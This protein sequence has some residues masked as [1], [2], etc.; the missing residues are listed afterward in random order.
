MKNNTFKR[1]MAFMAITT[2]GV[3]SL[4]G[5][6][7]SKETQSNKATST[8]NKSAESTTPAASTSTDGYQDYSNGFANNVTIQIPVYDRAFEGWNV[9]DNYWTKW[10]QSEFGDKYNVTVEYVAIGRSTEVNDY[11]QM[12]A[13]GTAPDII[14]HYDMPQA[15]SYYS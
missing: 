13:A 7:S 4:A 8:N 15:V 11:N 10:V 9:A 5:C 3:G 12:L 14:F 6:G 1:M 2:M